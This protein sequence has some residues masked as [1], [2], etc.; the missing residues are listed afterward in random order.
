LSATPS[1]HRTRADDELLL[2]VTP[3]RVPRHLLARRRLLAAETRLLESPVRL[4]Q[5][6]PGFG[7]TSLLAQW[8][9]EHLAHGTVV[10]WLLAQPGDDAQHLVRALALSVRQGAG[11]PGFGHTLLDGEPAA[12]LAGV[13]AWLA[14]V[15]QS[16]LDVVLIVDEADRLQPAAREALSY[17]LHNAPANLRVVV[18]AR[19]GFDLGITD[20]VDYG[21]CAVVD[22]AMLRFGLEETIALVRERLG[23]ATDADAAARLHDLTEGWPLGLQLALAAV[24]AG[25]E[26]RAVV[27]ALAAPGAAPRERLLE[28]LLS[29]ADPDDLSFLTRIAVVDPLHADLCVAVTGRPD[30]AARLERLARE[31][32]LFTAAEQGGWLRLHALARDSLRARVDALPVG[33]RSALHARAAAWLE[34]QGWLEPAASHAL[35]AGESERAY[36]LAERSLYESTLTR[37][38]RAAVLAWLEHLPAPAL[39]RRPRLLLAIAWAL[40]LGNRHDEAGRWVARLQAQDGIDAALRC[41]CAL[42][43]SGAAVFAD[44]PDRFA[45]LHD[46]WEVAPPLRD[47]V[48]RLVHANRSAFRSLLEGEPALARLRQQRALRETAGS[49]YVGRWSDFIV[50]LSYLWEGQVLLAE[51]VLRPA[52]AGAEAS[53]GRRSA[54]PSMLA[55]LL[56]A[57]VWEGD[58][59]DE[60]QA[61]LAHRMDVIEHDGLPE[62]VLLG[63]RTLARVAAAAGAEH[64]ALDLLAALDAV[65]VARNLPRLRIASLSDQVR[66]HARRYRVETCRELVLRI[67]VLLADPVLPQGRLW[68]R[69]V[70]VLGDLARGYAAVAA[71]DWRGAIEALGRA[72][73]LALEIRQGRLH[74]ELLALRAYA[75]DRCGERSQHLLREA[76]DLA[77]AMGLVRVFVDAHPTL[78]DWVAGLAGQGAQGARALGA[79]VAPVRAAPPREPTPLRAAPSLALTPKEREVLELLARNLSNKEIGLAMQVGEETVKWHLKNLFAKL[80]AGTRKQLVQRARILGLLATPD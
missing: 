65:G 14:E 58:R 40:A 70:A 71:Q 49:A 41:E 28:L 1:T 19:T 79:L 6:P 7:K 24:A 44:D 69:S 46:P 5:A 39:D 22:A 57:A 10:A 18:A 68:R 4:V 26:L 31:T 56:A 77:A 55:A 13:T 63:Y 66:L 12:G 45:E 61:L 9:R 60:A 32:P 73:A 34:A 20:L 72:D 15:A 23:A 75:Q 16:A 51:A 17:L 11:R 50:G 3:P 59:P 67:E 36:A 76:T 80:D 21:Q 48:L 74:I 33:E 64:R 47:P 78:G 53:L 54:F 27:A 30:D 52:L 42:I 37:G 25:G 35:A 43:L 2:R 29:R 8:R 38:R 62:T